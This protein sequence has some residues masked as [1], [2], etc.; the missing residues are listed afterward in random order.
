[1][2]LTCLQTLITHTHRHTDNRVHNQLLIIMT[3]LGACLFCS[4]MLLRRNRRWKCSINDDVFVTCVCVLVFRWRHAVPS[5]P[6]ALQLTQT[7]DDPPVIAVTWQPP[8]NAHGRLQGY[9][10][11]Y[12]IRADS[13]VEERRFDADKRRFTTGFLGQLL[14]FFVKFLFN[15]QF[16]HMHTLTLKIKVFHSYRRHHRHLNLLRRCLIKAHGS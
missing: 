6:R 13:Y 5:V 8:R 3:W 4:Y 14:S 2:K 10:L 11:T 15:F 1:L 12:G 7:Q 9:K 16:I